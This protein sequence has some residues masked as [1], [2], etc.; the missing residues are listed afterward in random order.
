MERM[1]EDAIRGEQVPGQAGVGPIGLEGFSWVVTL[2]KN[3]PVCA[4]AHACN[5]RHGSRDQEIETILVT[6]VKP[7]LY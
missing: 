7:R 5:P 3:I 1:V 4:V 2:L 6:M